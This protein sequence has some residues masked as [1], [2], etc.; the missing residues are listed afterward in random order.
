MRMQNERLKTE[1]KTAYGEI[2]ELR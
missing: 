1:L 2:A